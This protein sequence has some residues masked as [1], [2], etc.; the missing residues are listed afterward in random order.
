[1]GTPARFPRNSVEHLLGRDPI[2]A[3]AR[4]VVLGWET[5][6]GYLFAMKMREEQQKGVGKIKG[7]KKVKG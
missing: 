6:L 4:Q 7:K 1:M 5:Q 3:D 2:R